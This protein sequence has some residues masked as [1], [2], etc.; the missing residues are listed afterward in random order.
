MYV[1]INSI[2]KEFSFSIN[3]SHVLW[4]GGNDTE[5][6]EAPTPQKKYAKEFGVFEE[7]QI[8]AKM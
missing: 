5:T 6:D 4:G 2:S 3:T 7:A 1:L 8:I